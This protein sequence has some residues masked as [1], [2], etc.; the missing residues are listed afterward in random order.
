MKVSAK[1]V[2]AVRGEKMFW[3]MTDIV[4][5]RSF[6]KLARDSGRS[7]ETLEIKG[8]SGAIERRSQ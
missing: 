3:Q 7:F 5:L 2:S 1:V 6:G 8:V 4:G